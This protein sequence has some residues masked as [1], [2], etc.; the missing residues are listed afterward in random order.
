MS[1]RKTQ[2]PFPVMENMTVKQVRE[3]LKCKQSI[4][5]PM[6]VI[7]QHGYHLPLKTDALVATHLGSRKLADKG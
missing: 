6:G 3:Y 7:E 2:T 4:I 5:I 1:E